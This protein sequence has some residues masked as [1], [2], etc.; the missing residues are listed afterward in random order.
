MIFANLKSNISMGLC[1]NMDGLPIANSSKYQFW[2]ILASVWGK[3][4]IKSISNF[5]FG[6]MLIDEKISD[7]PNFRPFVIAIWCGDGKAILNEFL[8]QFVHEL[9]SL[10]VTGISINNYH[11]RVSVKAFICDTPARSYIKGFYLKVNF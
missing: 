10:L 8:A 3:F 9:N 4:R 6:I 2:P 7:Y 1:I 11:I 5:L